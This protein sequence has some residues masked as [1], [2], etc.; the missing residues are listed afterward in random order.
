M[1]NYGVCGF[2]NDPEGGRELFDFAKDMGIETIV[3]E[4]PE[5]AFD[6]LDKL[7]E[8]YG[9]NLAIHDH[10]KPSHYWNPDIVLAACKN[11]SKRI[12]ACCDTGHW[13]RSGLVPFEC[14]KKLEGRI[15]SFHFKDLNAR[16]GHDVAWGTGV[17][18]VKGMLTEVHRQGVKAVFSIEW[19]YN[20]DNSVPDMAPWSSSS[21][22]LPP[23][24]A[25]RR[26][27]APL[28][29]YAD[30]YA[31]LRNLRVYFLFQPVPLTGHL[32]KR[33]SFKS[34]CPRCFIA[35]TCVNAC[36]AASS[37]SKNGCLGDLRR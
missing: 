9:I 17:C 28:A 25:G 22:S 33:Y 19:E 13:L 32:V 21:T 5:D 27:S 36:T 4:P 23:G 3:S 18:D 2:S 16:D 15:I 34:S 8:E 35:I 31:N 26:K 6:L 24:W 37:A 10:P 12:G 11:H 20:W 29:D 14:L 1:V 30:P 7:T